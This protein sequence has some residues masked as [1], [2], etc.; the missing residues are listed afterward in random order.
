MEKINTGSAQFFEW[1][2]GPKNHQLGECTTHPDQLLETTSKQLTT[3]PHNLLNLEPTWSKATQLATELH[4]LKQ[5][6]PS[7]TTAMGRKWLTDN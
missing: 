7:I 3:L 5:E 2:L 4:K 1:K 6:K